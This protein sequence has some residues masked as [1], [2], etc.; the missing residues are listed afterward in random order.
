ME[1]EK[2]VHL[3]LSPKCGFLLSDNHAT[4]L[5]MTSILTAMSGHALYLDASLTMRFRDATLLPPLQARC[6]H[7][8]DLRSQWRG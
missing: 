1:K 7:S 3:E 5:Q 6:Y 2:R 4:T 8:P